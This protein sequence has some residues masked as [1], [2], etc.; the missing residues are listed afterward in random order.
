MSPRYVRDVMN[1]RWP[2]AHLDTPYK[3][4]VELLAD[5]GVSALP[6]VDGGR[7]AGVV[8]ETDL[9]PLAAHTVERRVVHDPR[10]AGEMHQRM[11][12]YVAGDLMTVPA[13]TVHDTDTVRHA[14]NLAEARGVHQLFVIDASH[15]LV[16][17]VTRTDLLSEFR[18]GDDEIRA[19]VEGVVSDV[20]T[21]E[22]GTVSVSVTDGVV[23]LSGQLETAA[24]RDAFWST[25]SDVAGVVRVEDLLSTPEHARR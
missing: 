2:L 5:P 25:V 15:T 17:A 4:L 10:R 16:G 14:I 19:D 21:L 7:L 3:R 13:V 22:P 11:H 24:I 18:R 6:V 12:A 20:F 1:P 8:S 9:L 23:A